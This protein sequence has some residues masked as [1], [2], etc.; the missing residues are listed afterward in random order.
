VFPDALGAPF[1]GVTLLRREFQPLLRRLGLPTIRFHDLRHTAATLMLLRGV[2]PKVVSEMLG[3]STIGITLGLYS[4][5]LSDLQ[6][7][8]AVVMESILHG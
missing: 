2:H 8:A 3:H 4:H 1:D 7:D 5:V 6:R